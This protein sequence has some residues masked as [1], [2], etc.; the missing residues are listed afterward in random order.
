[1]ARVYALSPLAVWTA[2]SFDSLVEPLVSLGAEPRAAFCGK[3]VEADVVPGPAAPVWARTRF[4]SS[5]KAAGAP[6]FR[7]PSERLAALGL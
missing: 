2:A 3:L 7:T 5:V 6:L 4:G 1:M